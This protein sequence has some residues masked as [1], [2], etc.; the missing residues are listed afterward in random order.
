MSDKELAQR[1]L[2]SMVAGDIPR[3]LA[4]KLACNRGHNGQ[5]DDNG[6]RSAVRAPGQA[7]AAK[8]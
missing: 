1:L 7:T 5:G 6:H 8:K 2:A 4:E 3:R